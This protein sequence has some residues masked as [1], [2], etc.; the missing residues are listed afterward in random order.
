MPLGEMMIDTC[1]ECGGTA[2]LLETRYEFEDIPDFSSPTGNARLRIKVEEF[3]CQELN[4]EHEFERI[5]RES[6][7]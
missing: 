4:C 5:I 2:V 7:D 1:P 3:R 6:N